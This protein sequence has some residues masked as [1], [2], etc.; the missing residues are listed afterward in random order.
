MVVKI[1][2][3]EEK[4]YFTDS[5]FERNNYNI[6]PSEEEIW[7]KIVDSISFDFNL[8][9]KKS[10]VSKGETIDYKTIYK[11]E[12]AIYDYLK[13]KQEKNYLKDISKEA[14]KNFLYLLPVV[15][16]YSPSLAIDSDTGFVDSTFFT[17]DNGI[18]TS[19]VTETGEI[20]YSR[21]SKGVK[22]YK[23]SSVAKIKDS[24][25]FKHFSKVLEM[26]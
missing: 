11:F 19:M 1:G 24:R 8:E 4:K 12:N 20:H 13:E 6:L 2:I 10:I 17:R 5:R 21:V 22:I 15:D 18:F 25:D 26:L 14:L 16:K 23:F 9:T 7:N 3:M